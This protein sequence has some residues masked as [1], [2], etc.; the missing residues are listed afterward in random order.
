MRQAREGRAEAE[1]CPSSAAPD[2][3]VQFSRVACTVIVCPRPLSFVPSF[4]MPLHPNYFSG[5]K[6]QDQQA[7][8][9]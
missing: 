9:E 4:S 1:F 5:R 7:T 8:H 2:G 3:V 6:P